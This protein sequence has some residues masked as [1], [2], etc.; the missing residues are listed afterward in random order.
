MFEES[1]F[2]S[3]LVSRGIETSLLDL[4]VVVLSKQLFE[5]STQVS[6]VSFAFNEL[7]LE[8]T[9]LEDDVVLFLNSSSQFF[10][11]TTKTIDFILVNTRLTD[12]DLELTVFL[13]ESLD[14]LVL[15]IN[16]GIETFAGLGELSDSAFQ[17][18][19]SDTGRFQ[20][21]VTLTEGSEFLFQRL[22]LVGHEFDLSGH[23][24]ELFFE[25]ALVT[26]SIIKRDLL[27]ALLDSFI[28]NLILEVVEGSLEI[29]VLSTE[30]G[31]DL[32]LFSNSVFKESHVDES[33]FEF[34]DLDLKGFN[35]TDSEVEFFRA[36]TG[37]VD[38]D[39]QLVDFQSVLLEF[40]FL[41]SNELVE[42]F[43]LFEQRADTEFIFLDGLVGIFQFT[44]SDAVLVVFL[45][46]SI[47]STLE[48]FDGLGGTDELFLQV[49]AFTELDFEFRD[50]LVLLEQFL[51]EILNLLSELNVVHFAF[52]ELDFVLRV[53]SVLS[54]QFFVF[55]ITSVQQFL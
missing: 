3:E 9:K 6:V 18:G 41:L 32:F 16:D 8:G 33:L 1:L 34:S 40:S 25:L 49:T 21:E 28:R 22:D 51:M 31:N 12:V 17:I 37:L 29:F 54:G 48:N 27:S 46:K 50:S 44:D 26:D 55:S 52:L 35:F 42:T 53:L 7:V 45:F 24:N 10:D 39:G 2:T 47:D 19:N 14:F 5:T 23:V 13:T 43:V 20:L 15:F 11:F 4:V 30:L 38:T 36:G